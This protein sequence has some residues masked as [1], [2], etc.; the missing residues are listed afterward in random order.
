MLG[1]K[2][3]NTTN[4]VICDKYLNIYFCHGMLSTG[5]G[6]FESH[7]TDIVSDLVITQ[8]SGQTVTLE[9]MKPSKKRRTKGKRRKMKKW[10]VYWH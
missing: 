10:R 1:D 8:V 3:N 6:P 5:H 4:T 7:L 2:A 9:M